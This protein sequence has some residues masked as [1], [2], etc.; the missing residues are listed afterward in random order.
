MLDMEALRPDVHRIC[1]QHV[2]RLFEI[3]PEREYLCG[4]AGCLETGTFS[5]Y[6]W[7]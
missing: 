3:C 5:V 1:T 2:P 6:S 4:A 7:E